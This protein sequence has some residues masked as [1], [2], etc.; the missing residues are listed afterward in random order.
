MSGISERNSLESA[1]ITLQ[2]TARAVAFSTAEGDV[3]LTELFKVI[4][5][6]GYY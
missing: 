6:P 5:S 4:G 3:A 2:Q 1:N